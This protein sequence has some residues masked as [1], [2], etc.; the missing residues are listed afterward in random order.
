[1]INEKLRLEKELRKLVPDIYG[2]HLQRVVDSYVESWRKYHGIFHPLK[3]LHV[4]SSVNTD[5]SSEDLRKVK[6]MIIY[7]DVIYQLGKTT[8]W[9][10]WQSAYVM[11]MHLSGLEP[12]IFISDVYKGITASVT[13]TLENVPEALHSIVSWFIDIDLF[14]GLGSSSDEFQMNTAL[15]RDEYSSQYTAEE[16]NIGRADWAASMLKREKIYQTAHFSQYENVARLE[17]Q[18]LCD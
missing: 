5:L 14:V 18:K 7:H 12:P 11:T 9:N 17:L 2:E 1:M 4:L 10:E 8:G 15:I 13:H 6:L 16:F 3:M